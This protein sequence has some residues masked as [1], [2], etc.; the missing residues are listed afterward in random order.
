MQAWEWVAVGY[1]VYLIA[2]AGRARSR[3]STIV[4]VAGG[5]IVIATITATARILPAPPL[6]PVRLWLPA[7]AILAGYWLSGFFFV[8]PMRHWEE[9]LGRYD[10]LT[11]IEPGRLARIR[12][13]PRPV[14]E[15][16]ELAYFACPALIPL[17]CLILGASPSLDEASRYWTPVVASQ[18]I[19]FGAL[20]WIQTRPPRMLEAA[21]GDGP[22]LAASHLTRALVRHATIGA[23]T[24][25]SGHVAAALT[26]ALVTARSHPWLGGLLLVVAGTVTAASVIGR[27]HYGLDAVAGALV[28]L[29]SVS[30]SAVFT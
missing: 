22:A 24:F 1:F 20:P 2:L 26:V 19:S 9:W 23:N 10:R 3:A 30:L 21:H 25:P 27:Y 28:A 13:W 4:V 16:L 12:H 7:A 17:G 8:A 6:S 14:G 29:G 15:L 18:F 11:L 5:L